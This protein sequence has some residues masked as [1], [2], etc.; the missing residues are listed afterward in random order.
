MDQKVVQLRA[1]DGEVLSQ[2]ESAASFA[3]KGFLESLIEIV[4]ARLDK[5][6]DGSDQFK[7]ELRILKSATRAFTIILPFLFKTV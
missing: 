5:E 4:M 7:E 6:D 2:P 3:T 1:F